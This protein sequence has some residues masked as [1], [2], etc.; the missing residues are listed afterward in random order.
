MWRSSDGME[1]LCKLT[2]EQMADRSVESPALEPATTR[3]LFVGV[4]AAALAVTRWTIAPRFLFDYDN[5]NFAL[6][7][8]QFAPLLS[9]P[10]RGYPLYVGV[11]RIVH[12]FGFSPEWTGLLMGFLGSLIALVF[13][14]PLARDMFGFRAA[15]IAP[16]L[17]FC[18]PTFVMAGA[19]DHVRTFLA[20][21]AIATALFLWRGQF[22]TAAFVL[23]LAGGFRMELTPTLLPLFL[24]SPLLVHRVSWKRLIAPCAILALTAAPWVLFTVLRSGGFSTAL[25]FNS[26]MLRDNARSFWYEGFTYRATIMALFATYWN[27]IG[28]LSWLW[29]IPAAISGDKAPDRRRVFAFLALWFVPPYL[30]S[31]VVQVTDP[32]QTLASMAATCLVGAWALSR[33]GPRWTALACLISIALFVFPPVHMGREASLPWIR[34]VSAVEKRALEGVARAPGPRLISIRGEYPT[35][36]LVSYYFPEDWVQQ[37]NVTAHANRGTTDTPPRDLRSHLVINEQGDVVIE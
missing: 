35:W 8:K 2:F 32:D 21:G 20:A 29:A 22:K 37:S 13:L 31:A 19:V 12:W 27:G 9:Q 6:A 34:H 26:A 7:L 11:S 1:V 36:R 15:W 24:L 4:L 28:S 16:L 33:V 17:L 25:Q 30:L 5:V 10:H 3:L 14:I 18:H 23:G